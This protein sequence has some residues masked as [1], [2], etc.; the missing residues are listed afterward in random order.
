MATIE[1]F[2]LQSGARHLLPG[3]RVAG[4]LRWRIAGRDCVDLW[5]LPEYG[6][7]RFGGL[8]TCGSVWMCPVCAAKITERRKMEL[9]EALKV[10]HARGW[11]VVMITYTL[12]HNASESLAVVL[13]GLMEARSAA[14]SGKAFHELKKL[15][16]VAGSVRAVEV[17]H[18]ENGWHPHIHEL[19]FL[20]TDEHLGKFR[21]GCKQR[22]EAGL[23]LA[24][25]EGNE[26][27]FRFDIAD[28]NIAEYVAKF[29]HDRRW[30][31]E[32]ELTKQPTK[33]G[34]SAS[35]TP[36]ELLT[37]F[38]VDGDA[39]AGELWQEYART[40]KGRRQLQWSHGFRKE[41]LPG[42]VEKSDEELAEE[43]DARGVLLGQ[44]S[45][46]FWQII[47]RRDLRAQVLNLAAK[48]G[49]EAV[50]EFLAGLVQERREKVP[51]WARSTVAHGAD[52]LEAP[53][54][55][56][57]R[58]RPNVSDTKREAD[59]LGLPLIEYLGWRRGG[60]EA[61]AVPGTPDAAQ[62]GGAQRRGAPG[63]VG[64][65]ARPGRRGDRG[66]QGLTLPQLC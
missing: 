35:R 3:E 53:N 2:A 58:F 9:T 32:H 46:P 57:R 31:V 7:A 34:H 59:R 13:Q 61:I 56:P 1:R 45:L 15:A 55:K 37:S 48:G 29:G 27:S 64:R 44:I 47:L 21:A 63:R 4:C 54:L 16:G 33:K 28:T 39:G 40:M 14:M 26:H 41:L 6:R 11:V 8:Q 17:T 36:T 19:F 5:Q 66:L 22:W 51:A 42:L 50:N 65:L 23:R 52:G 18:G 60:I 30:D 10:A 38:S 62:A 24:G 43:S 49:V 20:K 12:R 25:R